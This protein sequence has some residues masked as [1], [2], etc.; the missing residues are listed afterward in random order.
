MKILKTKDYAQFKSILSNREVN[1]QHVKKLADSLKKKNLLWAKPPLVNE[2]NQVID[3]QHRL[4]ACQLAGIDF[5][6]IQ[7]EGLNK[8][9][10]AILNTNQKNWS[11]LDFI[12]FYALEGMRD[13]KELSKLMNKYPGLKPSLLIRLASGSGRGIREGSFTAKYIDRAHQV[14]EWIMKLRNG[15]KS[16]CLEKNFGIA[17][18]GVVKKQ[19]QFDRLL[20]NS[21]LDTFIKRHS[22]PEYRDMILKHL[23]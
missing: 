5:Y 1:K 12:N 18:N 13:Y 22:E 7:A 6:Y 20:A 15:G 9:D 3:G 8:E 19:S 10:M 14:C 17:L 16:F 4:E 23:N 11:A 2:R 21:T